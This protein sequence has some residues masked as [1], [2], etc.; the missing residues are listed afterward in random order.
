MTIFWSIMC[1]FSIR[2]ISHKLFFRIRIKKTSCW[3]YLR[4]TLHRHF[5]MVLSAKLLFLKCIQL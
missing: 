2:V 1:I 5:G 3:F 4:Q